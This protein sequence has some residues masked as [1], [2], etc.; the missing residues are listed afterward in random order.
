[1]TLE[2]IIAETQQK[3]KKMADKK[4]RASITTNITLDGSPYQVICIA[5]YGG[6]TLHLIEKSHA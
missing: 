1:M 3:F 5:G 6:I 2:K 4:E